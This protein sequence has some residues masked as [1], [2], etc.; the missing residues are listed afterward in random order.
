MSDDS[1]TG[2]LYDQVSNPGIPACI[3]FMKFFSRRDCVILFFSS[4]PCGQTLQ[5]LV[6]YSAIFMMALS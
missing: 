5:S 6:T 2:K 1:L 4:V 3:P